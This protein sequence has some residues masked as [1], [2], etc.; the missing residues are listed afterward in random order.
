MFEY[1]LVKMN[2]TKEIQHEYVLVKMNRTEEL[3][4]KHGP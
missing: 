3:N 1:V 2:R 4:S